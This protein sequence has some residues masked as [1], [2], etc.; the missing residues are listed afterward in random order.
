M[1]DAAPVGVQHDLLDELIASLRANSCTVS[2]PMTADEART[3]IVERCAQHGLVACNADV[4]VP[5]LVDAITGR[6]VEVLATDDA[7]WTQRL[8]DTAIGITGSRVAVVQPAAIAL[9]AAPGSPRATSLVPPEHIVVVRVADIVP[10]LAQAMTTIAQGEMPSA[11]TWIGGPSR[12]GD[13]EMITTL[14]VHGPRTVEV[15]L[16]A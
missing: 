10:T 13:L 9:A 4:P 15:V 3:H 7:A 5:G 12:T 2:G 8:P 16:V 6:A 11:L 1:S 14:G